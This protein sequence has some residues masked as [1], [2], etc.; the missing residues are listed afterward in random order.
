V[1]YLTYTLETGGVFTDAAGNR[2]R[3]EDGARMPLALAVMFGMPGAVMP[4]EFD[5]DPTDVR[6]A[7]DAATA[8]LS[9]YPTFDQVLAMLDASI[10]DEPP[11]AP[12][13]IGVTASPSANGVGALHADTVVGD[14]VIL[15]TVYT[16][17]ATG[18]AI[19]QGVWTPVITHL[20]LGNN[21]LGIRLYAGMAY[22]FVAPSELDGY[23]VTAGD[24]TIIFVTTFVFRGVDTDA[25]IADFATAQQALALSHVTGPVTPASV[26]S[27]MVMIGSWTK[28]DG[29]M[30]M[31]GLYTTMTVPGATTLW[32][33]P[34]PAAFVGAFVSDRRRHRRC[35]LD[36]KQ[37]GRDVYGQCAPCI[38]ASLGGAFVSFTVPS[39][40][41]YTSQ[42]T[43][44]KFRYDAGDVVPIEVAVDLGMAGASL[45]VATDYSLTSLREDIAAL[46]AELALRPTVD[47]VQ[48]LIDAALA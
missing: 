30:P 22:K 16:E 20:E 41:D 43:G 46:T 11:A 47:E 27:L 21:E 38:D 8:S 32:N 12:V 1:T 5:D 14:L 23:V 6:V 37:R 29:A 9:L 13:F 24:D 25:P 4:D 2:A 42:S 34:D 7:V 39:S 45:P 44:A 19:D 48:A 31:D 26:N 33:N 18:Y 35:D 15:Y 10:P 17:S 3:F 40:Q 36:R 28:T